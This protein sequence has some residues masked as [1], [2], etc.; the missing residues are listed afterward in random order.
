MQRDQRAY[1]WDICNAAELIRNFVEGR[2][3]SD[4]K[5][6]AMLRSAVERQ[7]EIVGEALAQLD[8]RFPQMAGRISQHV[9]IISFR[10]FLIH[11]YNVINDEIVWSTV[12]TFLPTLEAEVK[13]LLT[14]L[15]D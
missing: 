4:Y 8:R 1:L 3:I 2:T 10:N 7:F 5:Q 12:H 11:G 14:E 15:G 6:D 13:G 9:D